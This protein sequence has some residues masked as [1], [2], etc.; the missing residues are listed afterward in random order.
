M[1]DLLWS[2]QEAEFQQVVDAAFQYECTTYPEY[3]AHL[4]P[5]VERIIYRDT[6]Y[7]A[8]FLYTSCLLQ[9]DR[10]MEDYAR[11][12]YVLLASIL[13]DRQLPTTTADYVADN[14]VALRHGVEAAAREEAKP[15]LLR[16]LDV[17]VASVEA[18]AK[19][20][21]PEKIPEKP[22]R[23]EPQVQAYMDSLL[24][25]DS[26]KSMLL[27]KQFTEQGIPLNDLYVEILAE[28]MRRVGQLWHTNRITV[29]TEHYCTSV[30]QMAMAQMYP[31]LFDTERRNRTL[32]CACPGNELHEMGARMVAD[33]FENDGW[34][35]IYLGAAVPEDSLLESVRE[36]DPDLI[37]LSVTM[38]QHLI[39]CRDAVFALKKAFPDCKVAVG[40]RAFQVADGLWKQWPVDVY[41][42]DAR[43]LLQKADALFD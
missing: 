39:P 24:H 22:C 34:D 25:K 3:Y 32:L 43:D 37:A 2:E 13:K 6:R 33:L 4:S 40:G 14:F 41:A 29:D 23:Y 20:P 1:S 31:G 26:R 38:P 36:S 9:D 27:V 12:L 30:T 10:V 16:L 19:E 28:S 42:A 21:L 35:S 7:N 5:K 8:D 11:W 15:G 17:A 18:A